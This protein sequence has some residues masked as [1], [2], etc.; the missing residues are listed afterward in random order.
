MFFKNKKKEYIPNGVKINN[1]RINKNTILKKY[2]LPN[3]KKIVAYVG[4][5]A[6]E[7]RVDLVIRSAK[8]NCQRDDIIYL[9]CGSGDEEN[10]IKELISSYKLEN[11]VFM[12]GHISNIQEIYSILDIL[13]LA[14]DTEGTPRVVL[15]A[16]SNGICV[17]AT[18]VGGLK[19]II[20]NNKNG[21][22]VNKGDYKSISE[23]I[24][25][26]L[27]NDA[28][29]KKYAE[30]GKKKIISKFNIIEMGKKIENIYDVLS[31][32]KK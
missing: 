22:L 31:R 24:D 20:D 18:N 17:V 21:V 19:E 8:I 28:I 7:K 15:E 12:L 3:N 27:S 23:N 26:L 16:M 5:L 13:V 30:F 10:K 6:P 14:S 4:R 2:N 9:I 1:T 25:Y 11:K 32:V 29:R